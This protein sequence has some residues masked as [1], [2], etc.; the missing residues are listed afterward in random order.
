LSIAP[1]TLEQMR[2]GVPAFDAVPFAEATRR[3]C[4]ALRGSDGALSIVLGD[5]Y[6]LDTQD[7]LESRLAEPFAYRVAHRH[8]VTAWLSQQ[9]TGLRA[10]DGISKDFSETVN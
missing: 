4:I 3:A 9:E 5:P 2:A 8:D 10:L 1:I 7:W 6:D